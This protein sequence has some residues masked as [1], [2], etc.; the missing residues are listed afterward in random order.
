M[1]LIACANVANLLLARATG[2][3]REIAIRAAMGAGRGRIVRQLLTESVLLSLIGGVL[4]P[5]IGAG[6]VRAL[7]G[8]ESRQ[9][10]AHRHRTA[11]AV[12]LDWTVLAFTLLLS[13]Y[14]ASS[15]DCS[16][17][18]TLRAPTSIR[19]LKET[20]ARSGV[21]PAPE[22]DAQPAGDH[23]NGPGH[24]AAGGRR[25]ADPHVCRA[26][27]VAPGFDPHNV[28]TMDTSLT[29][30][31]FDQTAAIADLARQATER[32]EALPG[33]GG[34]RGELLSAARGRARPALLDRGPAATNERQSRGGAGWA[35]VT[36]RFFDVFKVPIVRGRGFTAA[37]RCR[38][39]G[40]GAHQRGLGA[41]VSGRS[42]IPSANALASAP[43]WGPAFAEPRA[44]DHRRRRRRPRCGPQQ[45]SRPTRCSFPSPRSATA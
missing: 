16:R 45:R 14:R 22:Q 25:S 4:G 20:G 17:R 43:A 39:S 38:R 11:S 29:G 8:P 37:R 35:Y 6:G 12:T 44:R 31:H 34:G 2:R 13:F 5:G 27:Q 36:H 24:R 3:A 42:R 9:H 26:A 33:R 10:P 15:S 30:T 23:R 1:L 18:S 21:G 28:L 40:R 32:I 7:A 19:T 41:A